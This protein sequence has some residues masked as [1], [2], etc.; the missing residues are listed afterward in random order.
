MSNLWIS[1]QGFKIV[2]LK[3]CRVMFFSFI[4]N[5]IILTLVKAHYKSRQFQTLASIAI[6]L[7][8]LELEF[9]ENSQILDWKES[10]SPLVFSL[11]VGG[12]VSKILYC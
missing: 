1:K 3:F 2:T 5:I 9:G 12:G 7:D 4:L 10:K 6:V 8:S 11:G